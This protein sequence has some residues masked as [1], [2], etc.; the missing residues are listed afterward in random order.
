MPRRRALVA[1]V[2]LA[3]V[4]VTL[5]L[6]LVREHAQAHAGVASFCAIN[7]YVNCDRVATSRFSVVLG[8]PVAVWG[9]LGY[10]LALVLALAGLGQRRPHPSWPT[11]L[12]L[13][14]AA[15]ATAASVVL[16]LVSGFAIGALCLLCA[17]SWAVSVALLAAA[18]RATGPG[19]AAAIR[20]DLAALRG[21]PTA[22]G[23]VVLALAAA[24]ALVA[25]AYPRYWNRPRAAAAYPTSGPRPSAGAG[26][27][28]VIV[29]FSD[30]ECPFCARAHEQA[31]VLLAGRPDVRLVHR[32]FPLDPSCNP[33]V[34]RAMHP[35]ACALA[36]AWICADAEGKGDAM[37]DLLFA[38]QK[39][40]RPADELA[41]DIG[42]DRARFRGCVASPEAARRLASDVAAGIAIGIRATPTYVVNGKT[43]TGELP[44]ILLPPPHAAAK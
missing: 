44:E 8:L 2:A 42:L 37:A 5:A 6:L 22:T 38:N 21:R 36:R 3:A 35:Q 25:A 23:G 43:F 11:G 16:A 40:G 4:G 18:W 27:P 1:A 28:L 34:K 12:L 41:S 9:T 19:V 17:G 26:G 15:V 20:G 30:F 29:E 7:E 10:A 24:V 13:A 33:A 39:A 31:R 14:V 32:N